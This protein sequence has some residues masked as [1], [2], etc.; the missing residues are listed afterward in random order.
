MKCAFEQATEC[1]TFVMFRVLETERDE[2]KEDSKKK[3]GQE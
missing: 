2:V 1:F 3:R